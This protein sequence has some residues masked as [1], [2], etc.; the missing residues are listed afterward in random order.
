[1]PSN[2]LSLLCEQIEKQDTD[3]FGKFYM[4]VSLLNSVAIRKKPF[5]ESLPKYSRGL[6]F[7][8]NDQL[9]I[10][11]EIPVEFFSQLNSYSLEFINAQPHWSKSIYNTAMAYV[12][13]GAV[14]DLAYIVDQMLNHLV[15]IDATRGHNENI[16]NYI[17]FSEH[18]AGL[19][20]AIGQA[21]VFNKQLLSVVDS[22]CNTALSVLAIITGSILVLATIFSVIPSVIGLGLVGGGL[23]GADYFYNQLEAQGQELK[24]Q[25]EQLTCKSVDLATACVLDGDINSIAF[26]AAAIMP[27]PYAALTIVE[28]LMVDASQ[29]AELTRAREE[30][31][32][33]STLLSI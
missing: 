7:W 15:E 10:G 26:Y 25:S 13:K 2:Q 30:M 14:T 8:K 6:S 17:N 27:L 24:T 29:Q 12:R 19:I 33:V 22:S 16:Y 28:Q 1:M 32:K 20:E 21:A 18:K 4:Y 3:H 31:D 23:Y 9:D 5:I 11:K